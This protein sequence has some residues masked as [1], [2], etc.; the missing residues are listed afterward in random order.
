MS[1]IEHINHTKRIVMRKITILIL[2]LTLLAPVMRAQEDLVY[3]KPSREIL[4][5]VDVPLA[6]SVLIDDSREHMVLLYR[7]AYKTI[8]ELS[9]KEM[10]LG[11]LRIDPVTNIGSRTTYYNDIKIRNLYDGNAGP[12]EVTGLPAQPK[13][14]NFTWSPDQTKIAFTRTNSTGLG[15]GC[16]FRQCKETDRSPG[17]CQ[18]ERCDQLVRGR[19]RH[20]GKN[21]L[22]G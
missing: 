8:E 9:R 15:A 20:P 12:V 22:P 3:Q 13:L 16:A 18:Y 17:Q 7:D 11:G 10:R 14:A 6:P 4:Q 2:S 1:H 21:D 5:L 19:L